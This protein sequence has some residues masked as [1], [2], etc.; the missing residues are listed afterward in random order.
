MDKVFYTNVARR[1]NK[2]LLRGINKGTPFRKEVE[3]QPTLFVPTNNESEWHTLNGKPVEPIHPGTM[4]ECAEFIAK[5]AGVTGFEIFG[6]TDY[7]YQFIGKI[8]PKEVDYNFEDIRVAYI[9]IET[10]CEDG[11][12]KIEDPTEEVIAITLIIGDKKWI[13]AR[14]EF[15]CPDGVIGYSHHE[16]EM[17][18]QE[19]LNVWMQEYPDVI[20]GWNIRFFDIP[21]LYNR[22]RRVFGDKVARTLSPWNT[23][24]ERTVV[25]MN[26]EQTAYELLGI[27]TLDYYE[28]YLTFTYTSQE[29]YRLDH[30]ASIELGEKKISYEEYDNIAEFYRQDF[31]KFVQ[32]NYQDTI[33]VQRL[34]EKLKLM[35][36]AVA[37]AYSAKVNFMDVYS[38]VRTWDQII[39]HYLNERNIVIP[40]KKG[41][42]KDTQYAGA[43]VKEP[44]VGK[45]DW[46]VSFDLNSLYPNL[47]RHY[48]ISPETLIEMDEDSRFGVGPNRILDGAC[49]DKLAELKSGDYSVAANGT[50]YRKD[51]IGF[52]PDLMGKMYEERRMY[53]K[54]MIECQKE[55][56]KVEQELRKRGVE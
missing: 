34:E 32:Y 45:H 28:L 40:M 8:H 17:V 36:L 12:P 15:D 49:Q 54:K 3:F 44:I 33:L 56:E 41:G 10:T 25:R 31:N 52:L 22:I 38:Q 24:K 4:S 39:Y 48:N 11:F 14:G 6:N 46:V 27:A 2:I 43:Y 50:C 1:G 47:I 30:I 21:Y 26:R 53:K 19:F 16:E 13:F 20:S 18:L 55:Y 9:D 29:S 42:Q 35:E 23:I 7:I 37:L 51:T 5:Y